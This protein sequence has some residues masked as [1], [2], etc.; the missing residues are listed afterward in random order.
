MITVSQDHDGVRIA[1][2]ELFEEQLHRHD[3]DRALANALISG[4]IDDA[5]LAKLSP[6]SSLSPGYRDFV[7][8]VLWLKSM[9]GAGVQFDLTDGEA[10]GLRAIEAARQEFVTKHPPCRYC[11]YFQ[12]STVSMR[13]HKCRKELR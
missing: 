4:D 10:E 1:A 7:V 12:Y 2:L 3:A 13:C 8:Y 6:N 5:L 9:I 11:G